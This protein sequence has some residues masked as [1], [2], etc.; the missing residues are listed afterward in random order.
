MFSHTMIFILL[1]VY[2]FALQTTGAEKHTLQYLYT[3]RSAPE[4]EPEFEITT[5][6]DGLIISHC[7]SSSFRDQSR[8]DW[9]SQTFT[10]EE[11]NNRDLF[12]KNEYYFHKTLQKKTEYLINT[13]KGI[14]QRERSCTEDDSVVYMSD[15]WGINGEDFL[16]LDPKTL[17]WSSDSP[18][19]T[20]V[21][22]D[23]NQMKFMT[24]SLKDFELNQCKPSLMKLKKAKV[25]YLK[26]NPPPEV[27][28]FGKPS[29]DRSTVS[30]QCYINHKY[31]L[32]VHVQL[33]LNG[34]V[35]NESVHI[36]SPAPNM[37]GSVQIRLEMDTSI[38]EPD[39]YHCVMDTDN[40][41]ITKGWDGRTL[42]QKYL[43][44]KSDESELRDVSKV[45]FVLFL[46]GV[47][48]GLTF[49]GILVVKYTSFKYK[50]DYNKKRNKIDDVTFYLKYVQSEEE[51][52]RQAE[53]DDEFY[54]RWPL[55]SL[56]QQST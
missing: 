3:L 2:C 49:S 20:P 8:E 39:R 47:V 36:S 40:L 42:K 21:Q 12:C 4:N 37:D 31:L 15:R 11:W 9:I 24:P 48:V 28:I 44:P 43:Y 52:K 38:K 27:Y 55:K 26:Q 41:H 53:V 17:K 1:C 32:G 29:H 30:L 54:P 45:W 51:W 18:L 13:T 25:D 35:L 34:M 10:A 50:K 19:A 56:G 46:L 22:S 16:T 14:I 7:K 5:V 23:W 33:T 6:F